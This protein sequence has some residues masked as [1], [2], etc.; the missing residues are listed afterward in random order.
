MDP[1]GARL[2]DE[3][4]AAP[5]RRRIHPLAWF[6]IYTGLRVALFGAIFG[7]LWLFGLP[8]LFGAVV[9]LVLTVPLS[10]VV[11]ARPRAAMIESLGVLRGRRQARTQA[12]DAQLQGRTTAQP[13]PQKRPK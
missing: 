11:L 1:V 9:A 3:S 13:R 8:G 6:W 4:H 5:P 10:Y 2:P 7:L 12:L